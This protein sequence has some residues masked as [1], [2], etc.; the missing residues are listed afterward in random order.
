MMA[1]VDIVRGYL[2]VVVSIIELKER[3]AAG[4]NWVL[5]DSQ[6]GS[7]D[8]SIPRDLGPATLLV[9]PVTDAL[10]T[11]S[12]DGFVDRSLNRD[13]I[14]AVKGFVLNRVVVDRLEPIAMDPRQLY[15]AVS[16]L[17]M[18]WQVKALAEM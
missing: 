4:G 16:D 6:G 13:D 10:K 5:V 7:M 18:G 12:C 8:M 1:L 17:R 3:L 14:W 2:S 15:E 9:A 11:T